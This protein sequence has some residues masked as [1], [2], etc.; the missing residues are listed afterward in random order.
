MKNNKN[1]NW[2]TEKTMEHK[3]DSYINC[4]WPARYSQQ[5][6]VHGL[7]E[8]EIRIPV[9]TIKTTG[10]LWLARILKGILETWGDLPWKHEQILEP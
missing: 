8:C 10:F 1:S 6:S 7:E 9:K 2:R 4:N 5:K 3:S